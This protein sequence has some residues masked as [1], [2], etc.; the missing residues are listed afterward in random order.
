MNG[1]SYLFLIVVLSGTAVQL[2]LARRHARHVAHHADRVPPAFAARIDLAQHRRAARYTLAKLRLEYLA[3]P[4][5]AAVLLAWTLGGGL[6]ALDRWLAGWGWT[7]LWQGAALLLAV[8]LIGAALELP[9]ALWRT[10]G[11]E[12]RFGFN[13]TTPR[14]FATDL[15]LHAVLA[16]ALGG[17]L[18]IAVLWLM[19]EAGAW[20]WL[21]A[22]AVWMLF[23]L[24]V[25]WAYPNWIAP[26]FNRFQPL[27]D[28][29]LRQRLEDLLRRC[30]FRS[31]GMFVMDG[32][33]RSS[34]GNAYFTGFG[35]TKRIV[36][37]DTL[38][39]GLAD[40]EIEAVL[41]HELG[42][43]KRRHVLK[44]LLLSAALALGGLALLGWLA[45]QSWFYAGLGVG[46]ETPALALLLF[47]F[48]APAFAVFVT[49]LLARLS[50]RHEFEAD[51]FAATYTGAAP[52]I[53]GLVK[54]YRDNASTLT[55]D[56]WYSAFH[57]SHPPAPVRIAHLS[58]KLETQVAAQE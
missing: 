1:F 55:P 21:Y 54:L 38:L 17:P 49:P 30:G 42:H 58:S 34:H 26:L 32:S 7:P 25:T 19:T 40:E 14:R 9:F 43:F 37:F 35:R 15:V 10:F 31:D 18:V 45:Q 13:R 48:A 12:Q 23:T 33:K 24:A 47:L 50:R 22:W 6:D 3:L 57:H 44:H 28:G 36:F 56:P 20:W 4:F 8:G 39:Q 29:A 5:G 27:A 2:W 41:A 46:R 52:L 11:I 16:L 51:D 53:S